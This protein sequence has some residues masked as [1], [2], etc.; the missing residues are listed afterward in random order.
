MY[1]RWLNN[2]VVFQISV[3]KLQHAKFY[4]LYF[5]SLISNACRRYLH[6]DAKDLKTIFLISFSVISLIDKCN[7]E[8][9]VFLLSS[10][11]LW[12][13][14]C[15]NIYKHS[16]KTLNFVRVSRSFKK[17]S[18]MNIYLVIWTIRSICLF[19]K[20]CERHIINKSLPKTCLGN[21][22]ARICHT[23][24]KS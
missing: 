2:K 5:P 24:C 18:I 22:G 1:N 3:K 17:S 19:Q 15:A 12:E 16:I 10:I 6:I 8:K 7:H 21:D 23:C 9:I 13:F 11:F 14:W 4:S 20:R